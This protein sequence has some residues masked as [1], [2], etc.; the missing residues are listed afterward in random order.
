MALESTAPVSCPA[1]GHRFNAH[2]VQAIDAQKDPQ[3]KA[4][5]LGERLN[6]AQCP[7][8][9]NI[10][11]ISVPMIYHDAER[12]LF[13]MLMPMGMARSNADQQQVVGSLSQRFMN[14]LP[15]EER[16]GYMFQPRMFLSLQSL[17]E[18]I[19]IAGGMTKEEIEARRQ[20][21]QLLDKLLTSRSADELHQS[22]QDNVAQFDDI[23]FSVID[24]LIEQADASLQSET[25]AALSSLRQEIRAVVDPE[26]AAADQ[27]I[28]EAQ[29]QELLDALLSETDEDRLTA[30]VAA[31]RPALDYY[32]FL[33]VA[34]RIDQAI[35]SGNEVE[36]RRLTKSRAS[37][38]R[39]MDELDE[40][41][42]QAL[43][44]AAEYL[45]A[46]MSQSDPEAFLREDP[47]KI[48]DA[49]FAILSMNM[50]EANRRQDENTGRML[51]IVGAAAAKIMEESAPPAVRLLNQLLRAE[52]EQRQQMLAD[53]RELVNEAFLATVRQM[54]EVFGESQPVRDD[55]AAIKS[56][57]SELLGE[58]PQGE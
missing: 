55:L 36:E 1:C 43:T 56:M 10:V 26:A 24:E 19:L 54:Q 6:M 4:A 28:I 23:F 12:Q 47:S 22:I 30:L 48:N 41:E 52:P 49:F 7:S 3:L 11:S 2:I 44:E 8:C 18:D 40:A 14:S 20:R 9:H 34:D 51:S 53:N 46:T 25:S 50:A 38:L 31:T 32:F 5:L 58:T 13:A 21:S 42:R 57:A 35:Q 37:I 15:P 17:V 29:R 27:A 16:R 33:Q 45:R 39:I